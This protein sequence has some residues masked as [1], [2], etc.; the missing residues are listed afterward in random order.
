MD[1]Y[2]ELL[3]K[4]GCNEPILVS[5]LN[6]FE[7][8]STN[9]R[10]SLSRLSKSGKLTR[11]S[12]GVYYIPQETKLGKTPLNAKK[13]ARRKYIENGV[14]T[15]GIY[16]GLSLRNQIGLTTQVPNVIEIV[17]NKEASRRRAVQIGKQKVILRKSR[18]AINKRNYKILEVL[19]VLTD[20]EKLSSEQI[21]KLVS[22][23]KDAQL[24][25]SELSECI[26]KY[27]ARTA[28]R[29]LESGV[30]YEI[31]S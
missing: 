23:I 30:L 7:D 18:V 3:K 10:K 16:G 4:F 31:A 2:E 6:D 1:L 13:V 12:Q 5:E 25:K 8:S 14:E 27:P 9:I 22:I 15:Y 11:F 17:T 29:L 26:S 21:G 19:E 20:T 24:S 28:K